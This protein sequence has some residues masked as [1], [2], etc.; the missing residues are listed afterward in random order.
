M[1]PIVD[2]LKK[3]YGGDLKI[4]RVDVKAGR[5]KDLA[6]QHGVFGQPTFILFDSGEQVRKLAGAQSV[7]TF[8]QTIERILE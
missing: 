4:Q 5:G 3:K 2:G 8:E 7:E 6:R 1:D